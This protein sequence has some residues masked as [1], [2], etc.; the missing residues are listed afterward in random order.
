MAAAGGAPPSNTA[1]TAT[2][3][4]AVGAPVPGAAEGPTTAGTGA[5]CRAPR[6]GGNADDGGG[7][8]RPAQDRDR[9]RDRGHGVLLVPRP[10]RPAHRLRDEA[11]LRTRASLTFPLWG[12]LVHS[13]R[14]RKKIADHR[15]KRRPILQS[16]IHQF[17]PRHGLWW[18]LLPRSSGGL[19][20]RR[21]AS[22]S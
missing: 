10:H 7:Q 19:L 4:T 13:S 17:R 11:W 18:A 2:S 6:A 21:R 3:S 5:K 20:R 9:A 16:A 14:G 15:R 22:V 12:P 8:V 1:S